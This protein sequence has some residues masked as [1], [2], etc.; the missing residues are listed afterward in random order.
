MDPLLDIISDQVKSITSHF[1]ESQYF[2]VQ[3]LELV[4]ITGYFTWK[5][6]AG[7][8]IKMNA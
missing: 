5:E 7:A 8:M 2:I 1:I 6:V 3:D 4:L